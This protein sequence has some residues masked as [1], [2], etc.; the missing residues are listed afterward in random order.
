MG[1]NPWNDHL[2]AIPNERIIA[3]LTISEFTGLVIS[4]AAF[5]FS[6]ALANLGPRESGALG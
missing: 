4:I 3:R 5:T 1:V 2:E 6:R